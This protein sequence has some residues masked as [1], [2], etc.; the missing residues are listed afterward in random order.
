[1]EVVEVACEVVDRV[2]VDGR[3]AEVFKDAVQVLH[4]LYLL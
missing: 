4:I 2:V 3:F 1:M